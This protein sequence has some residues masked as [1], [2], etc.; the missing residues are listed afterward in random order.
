MSDTHQLPFPWVSYVMYVV[1]ILEKIN[2][3][4]MEPPLNLYVPKYTTEIYKH[5]FAYKGSMLWNDLPDEV[6]GSS[7]LDAFKSNYRFNIGLRFSSYYGIRIY[8]FTRAT[9]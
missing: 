2:R 1:C 4:I 7:S 5:S 8:C 9:F 6:K 3:V